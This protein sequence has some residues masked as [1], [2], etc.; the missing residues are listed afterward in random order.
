MT[1]NNVV[2]LMNLPTIASV[3]LFQSIVW[4]KKIFSFPSSHAKCGKVKILQ[5]YWKSENYLKQSDLLSVGSETKIIKRYTEKYMLR[6]KKIYYSFFFRMFFV[7]LV[8]FLWIFYW[9]R[10]FQLN[11]TTVYNTA[12]TGGKLYV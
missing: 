11:T 1:W 7:A 5:K 8:L 9:I 12:Y 3:A 6:N 2:I 10:K 4:K